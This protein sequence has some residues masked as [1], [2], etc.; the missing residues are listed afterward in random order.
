MKYPIGRETLAK[1]RRVQVNVSDKVV[2]E[3]RKSL[4]QTKPKSLHGI[5]V[6][7][8]RHNTN[9]N[10]SNGLIPMVMIERSNEADRALAALRL[11]SMNGAPLSKESTAKKPKR[12]EK[13]SSKQ[14]K[15]KQIKPKK[16]QSKKQKPSRPLF[17][18]PALNKSVNTKKR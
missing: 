5:G 12:S 14:V 1:F 17:V 18:L 16:L 4:P 10:Y 7:N 15:P 11:G 9:V 8:S 3:F 6:E 2:R 13:K